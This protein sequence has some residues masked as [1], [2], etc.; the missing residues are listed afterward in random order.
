[1]T[2]F[3][4][5]VKAIADHY[6]FEHQCKRAVEELAELIVALKHIEKFDDNIVDYYLNL[7]TELADAKIMIDQLIYLFNKDKGLIEINGGTIEQEI[8][9]KLDRQLYRIKTGIEGAEL[10]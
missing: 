10:P 1:M 2:T 3:D 8:D 7:G 6:G 4:E 5:R 9:Y